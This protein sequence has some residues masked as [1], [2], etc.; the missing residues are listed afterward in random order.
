MRWR[1]GDD[2]AVQMAEIVE[3]SRGISPDRNSMLVMTMT[4]AETKGH[5]V[6]VVMKRVETGTCYRTSTQASPSS[7]SSARGRRNSSSP[8]TACRPGRTGPALWWSGSILK[9]TT[10][11]RKRS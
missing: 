7:S 11:A 5:E 9:I 3:E 2:D 10:I 1:S 6:L 4:V 8:V